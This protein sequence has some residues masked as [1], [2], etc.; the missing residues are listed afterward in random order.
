MNNSRLITKNVI[1]TNLCIV[2][3]VEDEFGKTSK[4]TKTLSNINETASYENIYAAASAVAKLYNYDRYDV[5]LVTTNLIENDVPQ[6]L[7]EASIEEGTPVILPELD[8]EV[9]EMVEEE[10]QETI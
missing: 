4:F 9:E 3:S 8:N 2:F 5:K 1:S 10:T 6:T 7:E